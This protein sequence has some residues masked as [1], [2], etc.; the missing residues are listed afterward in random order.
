[1]H[2]CLKLLFYVSHF[3][4]ISLFAINPGNRHSEYN[5]AYLGYQEKDMVILEKS[6]FSALRTEN[7]VCIEHFVN[8]CIILWSMQLP[9][10]VWLKNRETWKTCWKNFFFLN[11]EKYIISLYIYTFLHFGNYPI[12]KLPNYYWISNLM[13]SWLKVTTHPGNIFCL[14]SSHSRESTNKI[15]YSQKLADG[16]F[17]LWVFFCKNC[18]CYSHLDAALSWS[19]HRTIIFI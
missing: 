13:W 3:P 1:M 2:Q 8:Y 10:I 16:N 15:A 19:I 14:K 4:H 12:T 5:V 11:V 7:E 9:L 17:L 18:E 6:E